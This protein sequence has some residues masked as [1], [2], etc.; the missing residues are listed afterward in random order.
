VSE[1]LGAWLAERGQTVAP[2]RFRYLLEG[3]D[4]ADAVVTRR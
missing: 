4:P 2:R 1:P 3:D